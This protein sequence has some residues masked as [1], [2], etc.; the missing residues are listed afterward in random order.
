MEKVSFG[1]NAI[2]YGLIISVISI[3]MSLIYYIFDIEMFNTMSI[4]V[5]MVIGLFV[6]VFIFIIGVK[7]FRNNGLGGK[8]TF[9]QAFLQGLAIGIIGYVI[10]AIYNYVFN[11]FIAP[12][13]GPN[14]VEGFYN[15]MEGFGLPDEAL[16]EAVEDFKE[17]M[18]PIGM[19]LSAL[20]SGAFMSII[21][22]LIVAA[23]IKKD[24][25]QAEIL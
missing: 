17:T 19:M 2:K 18:T 5:N 25:T 15:M 3:L 4:I 20:K 13:Y 7:N 22:S 24:T 12:E 21:V 10:I 14:Q 6:I 9:G 8:I 16:D 23:S 11:A 1:S